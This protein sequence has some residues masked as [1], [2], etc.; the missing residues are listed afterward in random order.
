MGPQHWRGGDLR[1]G[2]GE[3]SEASREH[4]DGTD[5]PGVFRLGK[6][7]KVEVGRTEGSKRGEGGNRQEELVEDEGFISMTDLKARG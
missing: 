1:P 6:K 5:P 7:S 2:G 3:P 4:P